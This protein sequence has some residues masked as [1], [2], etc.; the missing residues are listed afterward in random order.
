MSVGA[1]NMLHRAS[2][3][4]HPVYRL[5]DQI[6]SDRPSFPCSPVSVCVHVWVCVCVW[7]CV[8]PIRLG[9]HKRAGT[10]R[11][12]LLSWT[13][14]H[15]LFRLRLVSVCWAAVKRG[16]TGAAS[17]SC[18]VLI[19]SP[20]TRQLRTVRQTLLY[21]WFRDTER[22]KLDLFSLDKHLIIIVTHWQHLN[23]IVRT[24]TDSF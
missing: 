10:H 1:C 15:C 21:W 3:C 14:C 18:W 13:G 20:R 23:V 22:T 9:L 16:G 19:T 24:Y 7:V 8:E 2:S 17:G 12:L 5:D 11:S 6:I 4:S